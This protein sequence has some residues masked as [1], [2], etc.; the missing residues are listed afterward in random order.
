MMM[1]SWFGYDIDVKGEFLHGK[2]QNGEEIY[3]EVLESAN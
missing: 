2:F 3:S 1:A